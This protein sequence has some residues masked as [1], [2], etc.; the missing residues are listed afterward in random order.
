[1]T[2][3]AAIDNPQCILCNQAM[4]PWLDI[5]GDWQ[6]PESE[7]HF[8]A[9]WCDEDHFGKVLPNPDD[10]VLADH[11]QIDNYYTRTSRLNIAQIE[12]SFFQ[13][14]AA[15]IAAPFDKGIQNTID[16]ISDNLGKEP[17]RVLEIGCGHADK[18][19]PL[20]RAGHEC[21]GIEPDPNSKSRQPGFEL[22]VYD[23]TAENP[24]KA[25]SGEKFDGVLLS[26]VLEHCTDPV[27][28]L[29]SVHEFLSDD[30]FT[31]VE[32]PNIACAD[33]K[34][35][36]LAWPHLDVPRHLNFFNEESL[37]KTL[38]LAGLEVSQ[39]SYAYYYR[40]M[41]PKWINF[42]KPIVDFYRAKR[43]IKWSPKNLGWLY[44]WGFLGITVFAPKSFKYDSVIAI[45][46]KKR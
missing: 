6:K 11:Y 9:Y 3:E 29:R 25:L 42:N 13:K 14:L 44:Y 30:G 8:K 17:A 46:K 1:M 5:P 39:I 19:I 45:A 28:A 32:V 12:Y 41:H 31:Y 4:S 15:K 2:I 43:A 35:S 34:F 36:K 33:F 37:R 24:P 10:K 27:A 21:I 16:F 26:H 40:Q 7:D 22:K 20:S 38:E 18:L 23:G